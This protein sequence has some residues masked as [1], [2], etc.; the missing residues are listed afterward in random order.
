MHD[1]TQ[2]MTLTPQAFSNRH[3]EAR[4]R[5]A[6]TQSR[7]H[8]VFNNTPFQLTHGATTIEGQEEA[9]PFGG[10][11]EPEERASMPRSGKFGHSDST[12]KGHS[13]PGAAIL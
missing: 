13:L 2:S 10:A 8:I 7:P 9:V 3:P 11:F 5:P 6:A 4:P 1:E 12:S